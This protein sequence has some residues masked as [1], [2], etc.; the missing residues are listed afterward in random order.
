MR[1]REKK[2]INIDFCGDNIPQEDWEAEPKCK[3][4]PTCNEF[5]AKHPE[6]FRETYWLINSIKVYERRKGA[7]G[8][9]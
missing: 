9:T 3:K 8:H 2:I 1:T 6:A 4:Y 5:V 7:H